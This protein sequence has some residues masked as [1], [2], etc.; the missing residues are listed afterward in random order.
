MLALRELRG[1]EKL[2][3][4]YS[5]ELDLVTSLEPYVSFEQAANIDL[6]KMIGLPLT[7]TIGLEGMG[8]LMPGLSGMTGVTNIGKGTREITG[9]VFS[10]QYRGEEDRRGCYRVIIKPWVALATGNTDYRIF[11]N[12]TVN[13][14]IDSVLGAYPGILELHLADVYPRMEFQVQYGESDFNFAQRL[15]QEYGMYWFFRHE[16]GQHKMI[17]VDNPGT[18][19]PVKSVAYQNLPYYPPGRR[20]DQEHIS[21]FDVT[22]TWQPG[23]WTTNDYDFTH[24]GTNLTAREQLPQQTILNTTERYEWPGD[25]VDKGTGG[26]LAAVRMQEL[27]AKGARAF[28]RGNLR[29]VECGTRFTLV[30]YPQREANRSYLVISA[31]ITATEKVDVSGKSKYNFVTTFEVQPDS[32]MFRP[33]RTIPKPRT[34]GPQT[35]VVT[36][37]PGNEIW[38]D[39]YGRVKVKFR[40]DRLGQ[41]NQNSSCWIRVS[42][43]WAGGNFGGVNV[44]RV[45]TEVI[46]D[47]ENGDPDRPIITGRVYNAASMPPWDLPGNATQSGILSRSMKGGYGNA[48]AIRF[49]DKQGGEELWLQAE[50]DMRTEVEHD[51]THTVGN[52]RTR[53]VRHDETVDVS[54]DRSQTVGRD[55]SMNTTRNET[56]GVGGGYLM[57]VGA[58]VPKDGP[59]PAAGTYTLNV[60]QK[61]VF[62]CGASKITMYESGLIEVE[63]KEIHEKASGLF[64]MKGATINLNQDKS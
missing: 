56:V 64:D 40:W 47:F 17:V 52:D 37:A 63:A 5:Y 44:P 50:R 28:G 15:M 14:I 57:Q 12:K 59:A 9:I 11:Q 42:Y 31:A 6:K 32:E 62:Q 2:S 45:G 49:E 48:N 36:G 30:N 34:T 38:T 4:I 20:I 41:D 29:D 55:Q 26:T 54:N 21:E 24:P 10:A 8:V 18:H 27:R 7:I 23:I 33:E 46:V 22:Q 3:H 13:E 43:P 25:Y 58:T 16:D 53:A 61:I 51:E 60:T 19:Q 35:A 39:Q 1:E